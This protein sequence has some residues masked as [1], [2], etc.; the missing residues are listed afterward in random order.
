MTK[1]MDRS[2]IRYGRRVAITTVP[3]PGKTGTYWRV[4]CDCGTESV[5]LGASLPFT[6]SCGCYLIEKI[7]QVSVTH[8]H[9]VD[10]KLSPTYISW[11]SAKSRCSDPNQKAF[12][13][14]GG[15]GVSFCERWK[16]SFSLFLEDMGE[17][18]SGTTLDRIDNSLGY[19][20]ENCRWASKELQTE[21]RANTIW[22]NFEGE[23]VTLASLARRFEIRGPSLRA[24]IKRGLTAEQAISSLVHHRQR[25]RQSSTTG[26]R[27]QD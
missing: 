4:L 11:R 5:V 14:Y 27:P 1:K 25:V 2:G 9:S 13:S 24:A 26:R 8:G 15:S 17:R 3:M 22:L 20:P 6:H 16:N 12:K 21:N 23:K 18:P 7:K 10:G 19:F